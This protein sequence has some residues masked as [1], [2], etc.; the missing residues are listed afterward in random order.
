MSLTVHTGVDDLTAQIEALGPDAATVAATVVTAPRPDLLEQT[1]T[2]AIY[3]RLYLGL[4]EEARAGTDRRLPSSREDGTL[5]AGFVDADGGRS[6]WEPGWR[7]ARAVDADLEL[8]SDLDGVLVLATAAQVRPTGADIGEQV[9]LQMP[10]ERRHASPGFYLTG[11]RAGHGSHSCLRWYL[12]VRPPDAAR[13]LACLI[14]G[15]DEAGLP[16]TVKTLNERQAPARPDAMVLYTSRD[17]GLAPLVRTALTDASVE[18]RERVP[19]FTRQLAPGVGIA[20]EPAH[21][22][23]PLSFGQHRSMLLARGVIAAGPGASRADRCEQ[24]RRAFQSEGL[25]ATRPHLSA[26]VAELDLGGWS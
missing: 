13:V 2:N 15:L 21:T 3:T 7:V 9:L 16:F 4:A 12:N 19:A 8:R 17:A 1:L 10:T 14:H 11:G 6:V 23:T 20:D 5:V 22:G 26:G 18:L 24:V 25:D